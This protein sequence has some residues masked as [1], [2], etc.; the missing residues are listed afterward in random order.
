MMAIDQT[1]ERFMDSVSRVFFAELAND[2]SETF[3][4]SDCVG[5]RTI[6]F[7]VQKEFPV[8]GIE[9]YDIGRQHIDREIRRKLRNVFG[10]ERRK[11]VTA[12][13]RRKLRA[14]RFSFSAGMNRHRG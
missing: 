12:L 5:H 4:G 10:L 2:L 14:R 9:A 6:E 7:A 3:A 13:G 8:L 1:L 11:P